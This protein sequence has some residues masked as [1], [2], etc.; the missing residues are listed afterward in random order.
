MQTRLLTSIPYVVAFAILFFMNPISIEIKFL[1][2][3]KHQILENNSILKSRF[4]DN[5]ATQLF[6]EID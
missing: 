2:V 3:D 1:A 4:L 6:E 5:K